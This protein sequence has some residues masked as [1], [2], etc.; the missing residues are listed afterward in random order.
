MNRIAHTAAALLAA[1]L[2]TSACATSTPPTDHYYRL[3]MTETPA[4]RPQPLTNVLEVARFSTGA[5]LDNRP[6]VYADA[7]RAHELQTYHYHFWA[8]R[9]TAMLQG[10]LVDYLRAAGIATQVVTPELR[11]R[12]DHVLSGRIRRLEQ[13]TG[14]QPQIAVDLELVLTDR[15]GNV[16][17]LKDYRRVVDTRDVAVTAAVAA[18]NGAIADIAREL[19]ADMETSLKA[20]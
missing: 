15:A 11:T 1:L 16:V 2:L 5:L 3:A 9:P 17:L 10:Q 6:L 8:D 19:A 18:I 4:A 13:V 14:D 7:R 12:A 20:R